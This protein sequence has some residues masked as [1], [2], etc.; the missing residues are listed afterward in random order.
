MR[1][2]A[3]SGV[4]KLPDA[5]EYILDLAS[6]DIKFLVFAHH[7]AVR[8]CWLLSALPAASPAFFVTCAT[9]LPLDSAQPSLASLSLS[10]FVPFIAPIF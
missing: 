1:L 8:V 9:W 5:C 4:S 6:G 2:Y 7:E 10:R 3:T